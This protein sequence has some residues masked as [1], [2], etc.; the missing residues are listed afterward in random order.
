MRSEGSAESGERTAGSREQEN[1]QRQEK[2]H[3]PRQR[4]NSTGRSE[5]ALGVTLAVP[6]AAWRVVWLPEGSQG[7]SQ[8]GCQTGSQVRH[9]AQ[10]MRPS[11][12]GAIADAHSRASQSVS[13]QQPDQTHLD[14]SSGPSTSMSSS[15]LL[16]ALCP[17]IGN[18]GRP[19]REGSCCRMDMDRQIANRPSLCTVPSVPIETWEARTCAPA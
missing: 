15:S 17:Y 19:G 18:P 16:S 7:R 4:C 12:R 3:L 11:R 10:Q 6:R 9:A 8:T 5:P 2:K 1:R 13:R 14:S